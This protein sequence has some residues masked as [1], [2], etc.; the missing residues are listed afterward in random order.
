MVERKEPTLNPIRPE[1]D[2]IA[3]HRQRSSQAKT[4]NGGSE[5]PVRPVIVK[6]PLAPVAFLL[7]VVG[8]GLAGFAYWQL[9]QTQ[10]TMVLSESRIASLESQLQLTGD[11]SSASV[12]ALQAKIKWADS[13]IRKLW[14]VSFDRNKKAIAENKTQIDVLSK[15]AKSVDGKIQKALQ[16]TAAEIRLIN[17]LL[18]S[19]QSAMSEIEK[20]TQSQVSQVQALT[21]KM[22]Q[23]DK[24]E[25][26]LKGR[27]STNEEAIKAIDAFRRSVNQ[28]LLQLSR[29]ATAMP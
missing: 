13:E 16:N 21:D 6:S 22:R 4:S 23:L 3:R 17:D 27:I 19:Q 1:Q 2:E 11:E 12:T 28:K 15:G 10:Q 26:E 20:K 9:T 25:V 14:G 18:D 8:I 24:L 7:A 29:S 5:P